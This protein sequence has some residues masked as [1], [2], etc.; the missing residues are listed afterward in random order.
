MALIPWSTH[1]RPP[2]GGDAVTGR[3]HSQRTD[4]MEALLLA[5]GLNPLEDLMK[6]NP[7]GSMTR[8]RTACA[9]LEERSP[10]EPKKGERTCPVCD[11]LHPCRTYVTLSREAEALPVTS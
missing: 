2:Q 1:E 7:T 10:H 8:S 11:D 3:L 9:V 5:A 6:G 4:V